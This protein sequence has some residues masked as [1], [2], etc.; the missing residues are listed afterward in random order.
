MEAFWAEMEGE[1]AE[2]QAQLAAQLTQRA[3]QKSKEAADKAVLAPEN[4]G[5]ALEV[6]QLAGQNARQAVLNAELREEILLLKSPAGS[7][8]STAGSASGGC[9]RRAAGSQSERQGCGCEQTAS[10]SAVCM[11]LLPLRRRAQRS[12]TEERAD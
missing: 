2:E 12:S 10:C 6:G 3:V 4:A 11:V 5:L 7:Q 9:S 8:P 1:L